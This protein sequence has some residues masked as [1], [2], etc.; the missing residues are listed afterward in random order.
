MQT[1]KEGFKKC[2][3]ITVR[4]YDVRFNQIMARFFNMNLLEGSSL[5]PSASFWYKR[6]VKKR[7]WNTSNT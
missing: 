1:M 5:V 4:I 2:T 3:P 6:K 7:A